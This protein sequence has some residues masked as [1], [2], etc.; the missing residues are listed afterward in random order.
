M[1]IFRTLRQ[2]CFLFKIA[3]FCYCLIYKKSVFSTLAHCGMQE[4]EAVVANSRTQSQAD[5]WIIAMAGG[6]V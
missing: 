6:T 4:T 1:Y 2:F 5:I 3:I